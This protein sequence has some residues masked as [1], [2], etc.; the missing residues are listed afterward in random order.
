MLTFLWTGQKTFNSFLGSG[1]FL[2]YKYT[3]AKSIQIVSRN[4]SDLNTRSTRWECTARIKILPTFALDLSRKDY[5]I[6]D[7]TGSVPNIVDA[8]ITNLRPSLA[9]THMAVISQIWNVKVNH[10]CR[11]ATW[12]ESAI[13]IHGT[14]VINSVT[15]RS[16]QI[17]IDCE[18][19]P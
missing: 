16:A 8:R 7:P 19:M 18:V 3:S 10:D 15:Q 1:V 4:I 9:H 11:V 5:Y 2:I 14:Y 17:H 6:Q 12:R 13:S